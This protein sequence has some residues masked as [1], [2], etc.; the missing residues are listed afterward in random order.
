[1][2]EWFALA[3]MCL[4]GP[5]FDPWKPHQKKSRRRRR[6]MEEEDEEGRR[7]KRRMIRDGGRGERN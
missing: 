3:C 4:V 2:V 5:S 1:M 6:R 7:K